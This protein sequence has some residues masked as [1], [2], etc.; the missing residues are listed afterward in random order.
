VG[1]GRAVGQ[2]SQQ[3]G[4]TP[5]RPS[6]GEAR[7][8][9]MESES[10][11]EQTFVWGTTVNVNDTRQRFKRFVH[12]FEKPDSDALVPF[13]LNML[14]QVSVAQLDTEDTTRAG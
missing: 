4:S 13:Y 10:G 9:E 14:Q 5:G 1:D 2:T 11:V 12:N 3:G 7:T 8:E 6:A